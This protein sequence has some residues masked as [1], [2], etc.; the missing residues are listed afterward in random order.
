MNKIIEFIVVNCLIDYLQAMA[1]YEEAAR[2]HAAT[3]HHASMDSSRSKQLLSQWKSKNS[4]KCPVGGAEPGDPAP[5]P[6]HHGSMEL[7][8]PGLNG[9][10]D[11]YVSK[12]GA[13]T[14]P[15][16]CSGIAGGRV[17]L[18]SRPG[19]S[20]L[21]HIPEEAHEGYGAARPEGAGEAAATAGSAAQAN[22]QRAAE[23]TAACRA[24]AGEG[25]QPRILQV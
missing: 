4:H 13:A 15:S 6:H 3:L 2:R 23:K 10:F 14:L 25:G 9:G 24:A 21:V 8:P 17:H 11:A 20:Q 12:L 18:Q 19:S 16:N 7:P 22:W 1:A 5:P